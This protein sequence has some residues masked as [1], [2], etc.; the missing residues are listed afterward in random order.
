M[1]VPV[2]IKQGSKFTI[3]SNPLFRVC[4]TGISPYQAIG[5]VLYES[6]DEVKRIFTWVKLPTQMIGG[7]PYIDWDVICNH[8]LHRVSEV[9]VLSPNKIYDADLDILNYMVDMQITD[10]PVKEK[11]ID[12]KDA[13]VI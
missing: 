1:S 13:D 10:S 11:K 7:H 2:P 4:F 5:T 8:A 9:A 12:Y 6:H 3:S